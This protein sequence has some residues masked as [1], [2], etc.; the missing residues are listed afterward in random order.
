MKRR[1]QRTEIFKKVQRLGTRVRAGQGAWLCTYVLPCGSCACCAPKGISHPHL[2]NVPL[3]LPLLLRVLLVCLYGGAHQKSSFKKNKQT[4]NCMCLQFLG[5]ARSPGLHLL[6]PMA[7]YFL[8][9]GPQ[10]LQPRASVPCSVGHR[11]RFGW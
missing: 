2:G 5:I 7:L 3:L 6:L 9:T 10:K 1:S 11:G 4:N 8:I